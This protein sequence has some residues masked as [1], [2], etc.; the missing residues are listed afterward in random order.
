[1]KRNATAHWAGSGKTGKGEL[2]TQSNVLNKVQYDHASRFADGI[3]TNPDELVAA[4]HAGCFTMK[5]SF[6]IDKAGFTATSIDTQCEIT[7]DTEQGKLTNSHLTVSAKV[8]GLSA[9]KFQELV[10]DAKQNCPISKSLNLAISAS[11]TLV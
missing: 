11:A 4:A 5:L 2:T 10:A 1:M 9:E 6:N 3:H 8:D 7:F